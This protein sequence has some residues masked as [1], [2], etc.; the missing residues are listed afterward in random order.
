MSM[1]S[2]GVWFEVY[3]DI[4]WLWVLYFV[5]LYTWSGFCASSVPLFISSAQEGSPRWT[6]REDGLRQD[7]FGRVV[8]KRQCS[9]LPWIF[10]GCFSLSWQSVQ[11]FHLF[12]PS[13]FSAVFRQLERSI[14]NEM[15]SLWCH[16]PCG[17]WKGWKAEVPK[18]YVL[19]PERRDWRSSRRWFETF[20]IFTPA[21]GNDPIRHV[22]FNWVGN[23]QLAL[24]YFLYVLAL[25]SLAVRLT[26]HPYFQ[27]CGR[28]NFWCATVLQEAW[29]RRPFCCS[30]W[31]LWWSPRLVVPLLGL[32]F[33][34]QLPRGR[35]FWLYL[36]D[37][38]RMNDEEAGTS[39]KTTSPRG[40]FSRTIHIILV[41]LEIFKGLGPIRHSKAQHKTIR[42]S[43]SVTSLFLQSYLSK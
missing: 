36:T 2:F 7:N 12:I 40:A 42:T 30:R 8:G 6:I 39:S 28:L 5:D 22:F 4:K 33:C 21:W 26:V 11:P 20:F 17:A 25:L 16:W 10:H 23:H 1:A 18:W 35:T 19:S 27:H 13:C 29:E 34:V 38:M 3:N 9:W 37:S 24:C 43:R 14:Q 41:L 31:I 32:P 15:A